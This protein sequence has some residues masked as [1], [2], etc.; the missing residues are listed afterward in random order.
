M[1]H[2]L[3]NM[4]EEEKNKIRE[5]HTGGM[6]VMTESF[7]R[8]LNSKL[9]DS[10]P[11]VKEQGNTQLSLSQGLKSTINRATRDLTGVKTICDFCKGRPD[12]KAQSNT[13]QLITKVNQLLSGI[14][15]PLNL[16][17]GGSV[18]KVA[19]LISTQVKT[20]EQACALLK[21]Y[22]NQKSIVGQAFGGDDEDFYEAISDDLTTKVDTTGPSGKLID[23]ID[24]TTSGVK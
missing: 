15:S 13:S 11:L 2:I 22:R 3:N 20:P 9:G 16:M 8:L 7:S 6:K 14:E 1:K 18:S 23:A 21:F 10:K 5:Q 17:G 19:D 4:S 12:V 24:A